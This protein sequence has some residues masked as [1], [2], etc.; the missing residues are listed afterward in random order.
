MVAVS[1]YDQILSGVQFTPPTLTGTDSISLP[2]SDVGVKGYESLLPAAAPAAPTAVSTSSSSET[3]T[4][5]VWI[6]L[7]V[8]VLISVMVFVTTQ[9]QPRA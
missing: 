1:G 9:T 7:G 5:W 3:T 2:T 6:L 8:V 4:N